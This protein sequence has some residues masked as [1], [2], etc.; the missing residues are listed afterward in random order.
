[1]VFFLLAYDY[2]A[3][4]LKFIIK[5]LLPLSNFSNFVIPKFLF[6]SLLINQKISKLFLEFFLNQILALQRDFLKYI[7]QNQ[8]LKFFYYLN[9]LK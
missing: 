9:I 3:L 1:M 2:L 6:F 8:F 7:F 5:L 4:K